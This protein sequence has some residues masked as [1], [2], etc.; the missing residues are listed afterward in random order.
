M[1]KNNSFSSWVY[2]I[3][4]TLVSIAIGGSFYAGKYLDIIILKVLPL[5][6]H[7]LVGGIIV[8]LAVIGLVM[9]FFE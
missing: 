9:K 6:A 8:A 5:V 2:A 7:Q 4:V 1:K 3:L